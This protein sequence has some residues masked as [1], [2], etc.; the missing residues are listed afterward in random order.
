LLLIAALLLSSAALHAQ[1]REG[2]EA[3]RQGR[4]DDARKAYQRELAVNP[5]SVQAN[6]RLGV[7]LSREGKLD[8]ALVLLAR[9]RAAA[10]ADTDVRLAQAQVLAWKRQHAAALARY[11]S[12]LTE[13]PEL[14]EAVVGRARTLAWSGQM[15]EAQSAYRSLL[16]KDSTDRD[17]LFGNAQIEAWKGDF[18]SAERGYRAVLKRNSRDIDARVGLGYVYLWQDRP[19]AARRQARYALELDSSHKGARELSRAITAA[20]RSSFQSSANWNNDSDHNTNFWQSLTLTAPVSGGIDVFGSVN[21]LE[22]AD[23]IRDATR[24]G[25][26]LGLSLGGGPLRLSG[27]AGARRLNPEFAASRT[28]ATYRGLLR[29]RPSPALGLGVGYSRFPFDEIASLIERELNLELLEAAFD[30]RPIPGLTLYGDGG[31]LWLSDGNRRWS[32]SAGLRQKILRRFFI[33]AAARTLSYDRRGIGYFSPDRFRFVEGIVGYNLES[34]SWVGG[35]SGGLG[36]QQVG[37]SGATQTEW[38]LEARLGQRWGSG[39]RV[40]AFGLVTNSAASSTTGAFRYRS[41]GI[42]LSLGL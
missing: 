24:I 42:L 40:E 1:V 9:A 28:V 12:I 23:P 33:G 26:E 4:Y 2:D 41:A 21:A 27:A 31:G 34:R 8:S 37:K 25:G 38:H 13:H 16:A 6:L 15:D 29:Y 10:P 18:A 36:A 7:L 3:W 30:V 11:D 17:A 20:T 14:H 22:A 32:A 39:N 5:Q 19:G 35:L